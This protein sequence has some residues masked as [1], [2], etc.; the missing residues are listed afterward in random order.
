MVQNIKERRQMYLRGM[1]N[2][3]EDRGVERRNMW[4]MWNEMKR[5]EFIRRAEKERGAERMEGK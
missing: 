5:R 3:V 2:R 4:N 1:E